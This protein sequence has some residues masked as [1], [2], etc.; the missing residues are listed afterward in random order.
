MIATG[1][2]VLAIG[3]SYGSIAVSK[4][5]E[6]AEKKALPLITVAFVVFQFSILSMT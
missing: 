2:S 5:K 6:K 4:D 3:L 1:I